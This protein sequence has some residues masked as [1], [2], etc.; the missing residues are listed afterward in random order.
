MDD[1]I[2]PVIQF[3][4][5]DVIYE[6]QRQKINLS[7]CINRMNIAKFYG[8][9]SLYDSGGR[10]IAKSNAEGYIS[11][12]RGDLQT[13]VAKVWYDSIAGYSVQFKTIQA[14]CKDVGLCFTHVPDVFIE[15]D[16]APSRDDTDRRFDHIHIIYTV[17]NLWNEK[18]KQLLY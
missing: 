12:K 9:Y 6:K 14:K 1:S 15:F 2:T 17:N 7:G 11:F 13:D 18:T 10:L 3:S 4:V 5:A 16:D 8:L